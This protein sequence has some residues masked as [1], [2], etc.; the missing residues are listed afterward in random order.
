M[1]GFAAHQPVTEMVNAVRIL[2]EGNAPQAALGHSLGSYLPWAL[3][4]ALVIVFVCAPFATFRL[5]KS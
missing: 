3:V 5:R 1:Q 2:T 4:W